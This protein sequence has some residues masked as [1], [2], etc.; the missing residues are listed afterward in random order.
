MV[1]QRLRTPRK[2]IRP[3]SASFL[4]I[5]GKPLHLE[6][7]VENPDGLLDFLAE[8]L[9]A[10]AVELRL[11]SSG[12]PVTHSSSIAIVPQPDTQGFIA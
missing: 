11:A 4:N 9:W 3:A 10:T 7:Y 8:N 12:F 6:T 2:Q 1:L 5:E